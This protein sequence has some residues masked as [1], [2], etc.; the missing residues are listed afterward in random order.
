MGINSQASYDIILKM[1]NKAKQKQQYRAA[2]IYIF[3]YFRI[4]CQEELKIKNS[5]ILEAEAIQNL[6][7]GI[8]TISQKDI[9]KLNE[10]YKKARFTKEEISSDE[11]TKSKFLLE[12]IIE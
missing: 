6:T 8:T 12:K 4:F 1:I 7:R 2:V 11:V 5:R 3:Y 9:S 10:I